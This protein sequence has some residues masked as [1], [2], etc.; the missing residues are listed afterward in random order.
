MWCNVESALADFFQTYCVLG[1][2]NLVYL[3]R[4]LFILAH[5]FH[6]WISLCI[7][8]L[9]LTEIIKFVKEAPIDQELSKKQ[10]KQEGGKK[11]KQQPSAADLQNKVENMSV[12]DS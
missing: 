2:K 6:L 1:S 3:V 7:F 9:D 5:M 12:N 4:I 11:K 8:N 10:K